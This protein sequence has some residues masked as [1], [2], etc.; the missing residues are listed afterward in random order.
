MIQNMTQY[1]IQT[2]HSMSELIFETYRYG[3][4]LLYFSMYSKC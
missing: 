2:L 4:T 1:V 3:I